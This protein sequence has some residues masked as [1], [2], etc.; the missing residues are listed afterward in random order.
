M[1]GMWAKIK[2]WK[3]EEV[4]RLPQNLAIFSSREKEGWE[5]GKYLIIQKCEMVSLLKQVLSERDFIFV[6]SLKW[7]SDAC[8]QCCY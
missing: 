6:E 5:F 3:L 4:S 8:K 1:W 2:T 7:Q